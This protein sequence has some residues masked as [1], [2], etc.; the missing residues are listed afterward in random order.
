MDPIRQHI[1]EQV[2][3]RLRPDFS[4]R[5]LHAASQTAGTPVAS[6]H[7]FLALLLSLTACSA[8]LLITSSMAPIHVEPTPAWRA[9]MLAGDVLRFHL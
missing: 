4:A 8:V 2:Q 1:E 6:A 3:Q 9:L 5:V 7:P